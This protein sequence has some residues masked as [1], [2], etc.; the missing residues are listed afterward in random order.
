[1]AM[2]VDQGA[3]KNAGRKKF[4]GRLQESFTSIEGNDAEWAGRC[5]GGAQ[6]PTTWAEFS[7]KGVQKRSI[8]QSKGR[9]SLE[10]FLGKNEAGA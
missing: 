4:A 7:G 3:I 8:F 9:A 10:I 5:Q 1:M 6:V 2:P